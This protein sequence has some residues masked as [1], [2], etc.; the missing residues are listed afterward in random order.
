MYRKALCRY[1]NIW[2]YLHTHGKYSSQLLAA[3]WCATRTDLR[4]SKDEILRFKNCI[5]LLDL[6]I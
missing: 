1:K 4:F 3:L 5:Q 2:R 6:W